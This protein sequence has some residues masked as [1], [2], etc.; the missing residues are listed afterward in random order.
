MH[1]QT[2]TKQLPPTIPKDPIDDHKTCIVKHY[3]SLLF[4]LSLQRNQHLAPATVDFFI[5]PSAIVNLQTICKNIDTSKYRQLQFY[6]TSKKILKQIKY[7]HVI[8][9]LMRY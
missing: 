3:H 8:K 9:Q 4:L 7:N 1:Q 2:P 5:L 6:D